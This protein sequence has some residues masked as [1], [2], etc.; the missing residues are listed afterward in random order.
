MDGLMEGRYEATP[1]MFGFLLMLVVG[2]TYSF[3]PLPLELGFCA[4]WLVGWVY[5]CGNVSLCRLGGRE[6][7]RQEEKVVGRREGMYVCG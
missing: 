2:N 6:E 4:G 3:P 1:N 5:I 7:G